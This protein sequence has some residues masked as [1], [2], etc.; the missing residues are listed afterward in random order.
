MGVL[1]ALPA[2]CT[3]PVRLGWNAPQ[4]TQR[5]EGYIL[6]RLMPVSEKNSHKTIVLLLT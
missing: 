1:T 6:N 5:H 2:A 3:T 4:T